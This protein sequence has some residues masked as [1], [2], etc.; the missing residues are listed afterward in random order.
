VRYFFEIRQLQGLPPAD[1]LEEEA[2]AASQKLE[3]TE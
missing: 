1:E 3:A 2:A